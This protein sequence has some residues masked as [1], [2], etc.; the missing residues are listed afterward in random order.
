MIKKRQTTEAN[1]ENEL[2]QINVL[3]LWSLVILL[4]SY[5]L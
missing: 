4:K 3:Y 2:I 5:S 1:N